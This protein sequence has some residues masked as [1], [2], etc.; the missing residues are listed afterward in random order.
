MRATVSLQCRHHGL[1]IRMQY[2]SQVLYSSIYS[3]SWHGKPSDKNG[4]TS[5]CL[6]LVPARVEVGFAFAFA[7][8]M[9]ASHGLRRPKVD[10]KARK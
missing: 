2:Q 3:S 4:N 5:M 1:D 10:M 8:A 9:L 7:L 6:V